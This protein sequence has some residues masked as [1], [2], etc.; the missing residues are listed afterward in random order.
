M[1]MLIVMVLF[2]FVL[3]NLNGRLKNPMIKIFT[4]FVNSFMVMT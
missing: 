1:V 2:R 4:L 3:F